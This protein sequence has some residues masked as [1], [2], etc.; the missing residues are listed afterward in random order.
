MNKD[1][2]NPETAAK[3]IAKYSMESQGRKQLAKRRS[4]FDN[5][6]SPIKDYSL[7]KVLCMGENMK[8]WCINLK[9][10]PLFNYERYR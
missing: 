3:N 10:I 9:P 4:S 6:Y 7:P 1:V 8:F 2:V 5:I